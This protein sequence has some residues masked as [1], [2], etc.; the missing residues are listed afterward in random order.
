M[1][2][3][4]ATTSQRDFFQLVAQ[5]DMLSESDCASLSEEARA[6]GVPPAQLALQQGMLD[7]VQI[8]ILETLAHP[9][10]VLP[11]YE[12]LDLVGQG[13]MGV[14]YR[15]RQENLDRIV[16]VKTILVSRVADPST[17][18]RFIK[19][20]QTIGKLHHPNIMAAYDFGRQGGRLFLAMEFLEGE[21][22]D[23]LLLTRGRLEEPLAWGI[24]RQVA[25]GLAH[26]HKFGVVHRDIK[27]ANVLLVDP[28]EGFPLPAGLPLVKIADFGLAF[29]TDDANGRTRLTSDNAAVGSPHYMAPEQLTETEVDFRADI[30]AL[31]A[32]VYQMLSGRPPFAGLRMQQIVGKKIM[33]EVPA[34]RDCRDE[35]SPGTCAL[36][37]RML[38]LDPRNRFGSYEEL[39][40]QID[41]ID[42]ATAS[43]S[44]NHPRVVSVPVG[45]KPLLSGDRSPSEV[46]R[47]GS[48]A[49]EMNSRTYFSTDVATRVRVSRVA[50]SEKPWHSRWIWV[51]LPVVGLAGLGGWWWFH[52]QRSGTGANQPGP[53]GNEQAGVAPAGGL[54]ALP[55]MGVPQRVEM[56]TGQWSRPLFSGQVDVR[57]IVS[58]SWK[59][60]HDEE[61]A[62][63][64]EG[65][66]GAYRFPMFRGPNEPIQFFRFSYLVRLRQAEATEFHFGVRGG[67]R[68]PADRSIL[69]IDRSGVAVGVRASELA[70]FQPGSPVM[71][72]PREGDATHTVVVERLSTGW[73]LTVDGQSLPVRGRAPPRGATAVGRCSSRC[74]KRPVILTHHGRCRARRRT[75]R[76]RL[77]HED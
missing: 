54:G 39:I 55:G 56:A 30:Y 74:G 73:F 69:R 60:A 8:D 20:A 75:A 12:I 59:D 46:T 72:L 29:L 67:P 52:A 24:A 58:G 70:P 17:A 31:G 11:G 10:A 77:S 16:A 7:P 68:G 76:P 4:P 40:D 18:G 33:G 36:V 2:S 37:E 66:D 27:P 5:L 50:E 25:A 53:A 44:G 48:S 19:E 1:T 57:R 65:S 26:A 45:E 38:A 34:L 63:V 9:R 43:T 35:L 64:L 14:V 62:S 47:Q 41:R 22:L 13:G 61:M 32:T 51:L 6:K 15:A 71:S 42:A 21:D 23:G 3:D 28:P 49:A